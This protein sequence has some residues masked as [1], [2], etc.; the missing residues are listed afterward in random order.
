[1]V[2]L[3]NDFDLTNHINNGALW[4]DIAEC[5]Q[6]QRNNAD[7]LPDIHWVGGNPWTGAKAEVYGWAAWNGQKAVLTLRNGANDAQ[8]FT[9]TLREVLEIPEYIT[10]STITFT[11]AFDDQVALTGFAEGEQL[12]IDAKITVTV[13]GSSVYVFDGVDNS[14]VD[15]KANSP[16]STE[17]NPEY[18]WIKFCAGN[19]TLSGP[20]SDSDAKA[21]TVEKACDDNQLWMLVGNKDGFYLKNKA[22]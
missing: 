6:W 9:F 2:E 21:V 22:G 14:F 10:S 16:F 7:V 1:M 3:Y 15:D 17:Q 11:K 19:A 4:G 13:P 8:E 12:D 18:W 20:K 5:I